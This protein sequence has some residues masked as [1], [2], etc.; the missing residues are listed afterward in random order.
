[1]A[2]THDL[3][4]AAGIIKNS[5][6]TTAFTGAG[7]SVESGVPPFRGKDGPRVKPRK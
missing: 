2:I 1:V 7:I 4:Q 5:R 6:H 3:E